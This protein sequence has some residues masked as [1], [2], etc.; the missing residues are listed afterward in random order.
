[1]FIDCYVALLLGLLPA[2]NEEVLRAEHIHYAK[3][4]LSNFQKRFKGVFLEDK[5]WDCAKASHV[6]MF[7]DA[8]EKMKAENQEAYN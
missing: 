2:I 4:L 1:M 6:P 5:F 3:H 8:M 7:E